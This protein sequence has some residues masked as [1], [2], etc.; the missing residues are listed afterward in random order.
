LSSFA[1]VDATFTLL[2]HVVVGRR[3]W[4]A[5]LAIAIPEKTK[6]PP[7][8]IKLAVAFLAID[9]SGTLWRY[10]IKYVP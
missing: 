5:G 1:P 3:C 8:A 2:L 10:M 6:K 4:V 7:P 9:Q